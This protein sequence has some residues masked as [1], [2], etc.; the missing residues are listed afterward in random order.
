MRRAFGSDVWR[1][2]FGQR[3]NSSHS[4]ASNRSHM[5]SWRKVIRLRACGGVTPHRSDVPIIWRARATAAAAEPCKQRAECV[6]IAVFLLIQY[7]C[8]LDSRSRCCAWLGEREKWGEH[9]RCW[10]GKSTLLVAVPKR[11]KVNS[12]TLFVDISHMSTTN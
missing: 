4:D 5:F 2:R 7:Y 12:F 6:S 9:S 11:V 10:V 8:G 1:A 3:A